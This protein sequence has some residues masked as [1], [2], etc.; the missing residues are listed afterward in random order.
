MNNGDIYRQAI[1]VAIDA[2]HGGTDPGAV[3]G[4][5]K[6]K[7]FNLEAAN[8]MYNRLKELGIPTSITRSTDETLS[9]QERI[10]RIMNAFG[11]NKNVILVANHINA[12]G[13]EGA[14]VVYALRS[15]DTLAKNVLEEI[16]KEG[17]IIRK[18]YQRRLP[19][20]TSKDY[21]YI[22]RDTGNVTPILVEYGFI[23]NPK[24]L[25][26]LQTNL[27]NYAEAVIRGI[28]KT[29]NLPYTPPRTT[30]EN[31]YIVK[32][33]DSLYAIA[34]KYNTTVDELKVLNNLTSNILQIG[35]ILKIPS[36]TPPP[37]KPEEYIVYTVEKGD[38]LYAIAKKFNTTVDDIVTYNQ[39]ATT[40]L[41]IG[42]QLLIPTTEA[43][44]PPTPPVVTKTYTVQKG[45]SL[46]KIANN[47]GISVSDLISANNLT[48]NTLQIGQ[49]LNIPV[50]E[51]LEEEEEEEIIESPS[52]IE[53]VVKSGDSLYSIAKRYGVTVDEL[54]SLNK[55]TSNLLF[56]GQRLLIPTTE[57]YT[58]YSVKSGDSLYAIARKYN[59]T[60]D[61]LKRVNNLTSDVL[62]IGQVLIIPR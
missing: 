43:V 51:E 28:A 56:I 6:E 21:Y 36:L 20:D 52:N 54:K 27:L 23:D 59:T 8:Y 57:N 12:G 13:G 10:N 16:G 17:Q 35:Q 41:S 62:K 42:Q 38:S 34:Q 44:T 29:Y 18:Y 46:W 33:G 50:K 7:D 3:Y 47:F 19:S 30:S 31:T 60:V 11:N 5:Y 48:N 53:Y 40:L 26:K 37:Q 2:G 15:N 9:R 45:D 14:E 25:N 58:T 1:S 55:L 4:N 32:A 24:D 39:L 22:M 49:I 61:E